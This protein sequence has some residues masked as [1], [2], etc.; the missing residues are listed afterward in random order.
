MTLD[1]TVLVDAHVHVPVLGSLAQAWIDWA[2]DFGP[3]ASKNVTDLGLAGSATSKISKP[4]G[5]MPG[6]RV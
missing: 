5:V 6:S 4:A 3:D 1:G 2:R